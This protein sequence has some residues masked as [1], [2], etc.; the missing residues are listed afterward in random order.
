MTC[1]E[2][3]RETVFYRG[4]EAAMT[5]GFEKTREV[6]FIH[7]GRQ[8]GHETCYSRTRLVSCVTKPFTR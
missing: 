6:G 5:P 2:G 7:N 3:G 8:A 1:K 4:S